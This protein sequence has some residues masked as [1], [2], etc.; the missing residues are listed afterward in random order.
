MEISIFLGFFAG[1]L[2]GN[3]FSRLLRFRE[4]RQAAIMAQIQ[5]LR[6]FSQSINQ[7]GHLRQWHDNVAIGIDEVKRKVLESAEGSSNFSEQE[8]AELSGFL[9]DRYSEELKSVW[10][11]FEWDMKK[12]KEDSIRLISTS[13]SSSLKPPYE[14]WAEAMAWLTAFETKLAQELKQKQANLEEKSK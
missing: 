6:L 2:V 14:T 5:A 8:K 3:V 12:F 4:E 1:Y 10:N 13:T 9:G 7:Y 11:M